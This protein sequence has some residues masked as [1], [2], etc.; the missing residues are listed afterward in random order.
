MPTIQRWGIKGNAKQ[1]FKQADR[2][3]QGCILFD[4]FVE[5]A[6]KKNLDIDTDDDAL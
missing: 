2:D 1:L 6:I 5:W 4:E 3:G